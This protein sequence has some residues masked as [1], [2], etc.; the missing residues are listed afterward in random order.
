MTVGTAVALVA[1]SDHD[2]GINA[3]VTCMVAGDIPFQLRLVSE[4][5]NDHKTKYFL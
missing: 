5:S 1:V 4:N 2:E 3:V